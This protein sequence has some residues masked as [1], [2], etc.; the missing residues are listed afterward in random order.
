VFSPRDI[1]Y[2]FYG[3]NLFTSESESSTS[4]AGPALLQASLKGWR[5]AMDH[6]EE[7]INLI[8]STTPAG[9]GARRSP[10]RPVKPGP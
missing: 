3:D 10:S 7:M 6:P 5:Y 8:L 4:R 9:P 2:D 1:G